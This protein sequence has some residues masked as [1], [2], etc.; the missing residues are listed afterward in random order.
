M[1]MMM[2]IIVVMIAVVGI[3]A[4]L[5]S[6]YRAAVHL[7]PVTVNAFWL[8]LLE[9]CDKFTKCATNASSDFAQILRKIH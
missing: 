9:N 2:M 8:M 7:T 4:P 5:F 3:A 1:I 6:L